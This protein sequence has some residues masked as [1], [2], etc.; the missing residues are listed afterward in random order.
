MLSN[1]LFL[2][3][4]YDSLWWWFSHQ[5][6]SDFYKSMDCSP[7]GSSVHGISQA[8][9]LEWVAIS[10]S[11][12]SSQGSNLALLYCRW[13]PYWLSHQRSHVISSSCGYVSLCIQLFSFQS[14]DCYKL[15]II[16][17]CPRHEKMLGNKRTEV[18][19]Q[20][21]SW[22]LIAPYHSLST[23]KGGIQV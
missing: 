21:E 16:S 19:V 9:I 2:I 7:P 14:F 8:R 6:M 1:S 12:G 4:W 11:R 5:V 20:W 23:L 13:I 10:F 17:Q 15:A 18:T 3:M 22:S